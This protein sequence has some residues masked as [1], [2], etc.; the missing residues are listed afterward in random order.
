M[1]RLTTG[2]AAFLFL[3]FAATADANT[4]AGAQAGTGA[5]KDLGT[6]DEINIEG[7]IPLPQV[8]FIS[9][10]VQP[11]YP[12]E[13]HKRYL[14]GLDF[15]LARPIFPMRIITVPKGLDQQEEY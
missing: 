9:S 8:L 11:R 10:R 5:D 7:E 4:E 15:W 2:I 12:D 13:V 1:K 6:L 14:T 3:L